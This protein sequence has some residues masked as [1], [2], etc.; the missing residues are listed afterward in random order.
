MNWKTIRAG[1]MAVLIVINIALFWMNRLETDRLYLASDEDLDLIL[2]LYEENGIRLGT[3]LHRESYPRAP[4]QLGG[5]EILNRELVERIL[6]S[7]YQ[8]A[9]MDARQSRYTKGDQTILMDPENHRMQYQSADAG[10]TAGTG[11]ELK[12]WADQLILTW[13]TDAAGLVCTQTRNRQQS[14]Q[15]VY[16]QKK[17]GLYLYFNRVILQ[18]QADGSMSA[19]VQYYQPGGYEGQKKEIRPLDE[20]MYGAMKEIVRLKGEEEQVMLTEIRS[21]YDR[22]SDGQCVYCIEFVLDNGKTVRMNGYSNEILS[23]A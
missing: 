19:A 7:D 3:I 2:E 21:G 23:A 22:S 11:E 12:Q 10:I 8:V 1:L 15:F 18:I 13:F 16:C 6:G 20:L 4:L 9:Y 17:E 5:A 14:V